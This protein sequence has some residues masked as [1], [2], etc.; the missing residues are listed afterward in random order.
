MVLARENMGVRDLGRRKS[1]RD[2]LEEWFSTGGG[3]HVP[4]PP[5]NPPRGLWQYLERDAIGIEWGEAGDTIN[6]LQGTEQP[7]SQIFIQPKCQ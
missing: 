1:S 7:S 4:P 2:G 6:I 3:S 5:L